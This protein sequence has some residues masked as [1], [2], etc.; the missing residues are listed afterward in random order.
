M[1]DF[2][3][4]VGG[5][6]SL[7]EAEGEGEEGERQDGEG[8]HGKTLARVREQRPETIAAHRVHPLA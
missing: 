7:L 8:A 4:G 3:G 1:G 6:G 2:G 5:H